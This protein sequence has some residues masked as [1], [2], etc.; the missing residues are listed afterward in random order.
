[1]RPALTYDNLTNNNLI[2]NNRALQHLRFEN[3]IHFKSV[4]II[5][6]F[7]KTGKKLRE[8]P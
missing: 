3:P 7:Q 2:D 8:V 4:S 5:G 6:K 1:M